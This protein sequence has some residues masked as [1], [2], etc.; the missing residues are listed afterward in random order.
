MIG[1]LRRELLD[2]IL[3]LHEQH[4]RYTLTEWLHHYNH[5]RPHRSLGQLTP[6]Q[7]EHGPPAPINLAEQRIRR[8]TI[9]GGLSHEYWTAATAA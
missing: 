3:I 1:T 4:A 7:A 9:L 2:H 5:R 8:R 6:A